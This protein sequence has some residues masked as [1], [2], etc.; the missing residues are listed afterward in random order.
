MENVIQY[1]KDFAFSY[2]YPFIEGDFWGIAVNILGTLGALFWLLVTWVILY[3]RLTTPRDQWKREWGEAREKNERN[4]RR[5]LAGR[6]H[7]RY[8]VIPHLGIY[9]D[10]WI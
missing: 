10:Y 9:M 2:A 7:V 3:A 6:R 4:I 1:F 8:P 5:H